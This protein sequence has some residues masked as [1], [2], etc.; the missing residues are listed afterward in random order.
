MLQILD[1]T[2]LSLYNTID[3]LYPSIFTRP[4]DLQAEGKEEGAP[5]SDYNMNRKRLFLALALGIVLVLVCVSAALAADDPIK[6]AMELSK[7]KFSGPETINVSITVTN[8]GDGDMP[9]PVTLYYPG[10]KKVE[11]F[12]SPTLSV[13][14]SKRWTGTWTVTREQLEVGKIS[15]QVRYSFYGGEPDEDGEPKLKSM[16]KNFSKKITYTGADPEIS[17]NRTITPTVAQKG[18]EISIVYEVAN[19]GEV[20]VSSVNIKENTAVSAKSGT[21]ESIEPGETGTYTFTTTMGTK[22]ITS[23]ATVS[24]KA[25]GKNFTRKV[26]SAVIK[27]GEV[28]LSASL[29]ADK[30]GGAPGETVKLTL[31]LKNSGNLDF[32]NVTVTDAALGTVFSGESVKAGETVTL[33]KDVTITETQELQFTVTA[34][35]STGKGVETA[36]G[37]VKIIAM[38]PTQQIVLT[39][40]AVADREVVYKTPGTVRFTITVHNDSAVEVKNISVKAVD[41]ELYSFESIPAGETVSFIRDADVNLEDMDQG[42]FQFTATCR[43]QLDQRLTFTSNP[44]VISYAEPTPVPTEAPMVTP[45]APATEP[46]PTDQPEPEYL[47]QV[48]SVA[49]GAKWILTGIAAVLLVLLLIGAIRRGKSRSES[50]KAMDHLEGATYRDYGTEPKRRRRSEISNGGTV[51]EPAAE[52]QKPEESTAQSS[53]LM[54]ETLRRLYSEKPAETATGT[55]TEAA[56][57]VEETVKEASA[58]A[59]EAVENA[60]GNAAETV[61]D[62]QK[63]AE[64]AGGSRRRRSHKQE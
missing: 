25:G 4:P 20:A 36:T 6:V 41:T 53:E 9:S 19:V 52:E 37:R 47:S 57:T 63:A 17:V 54:A 3:V 14:A 62:I 13:G 49:E 2:A 30:K 39:L 56:E 26:E 1:K 29:K 32:T 5:G 18:Q 45:A 42:T 50:K 8:V 23:A 22:D 15:F 44:V 59:A 61:Q 10:G 48:E 21:I 60:V 38:D 64:E 43:D 40:D 34:D 31:T 51:E 24:F 33:E 16:K 7:T 11:E 28:N 46:I 27:Y 58:E 55:V 35:E 12:G